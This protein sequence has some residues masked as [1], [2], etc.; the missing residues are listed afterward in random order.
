MSSSGKTA[1][2][3]SVNGGPIPLDHPMQTFLPYKDFERSAKVLDY[4]RLGKQRVETKQLL[5]ILLGETTKLGWRNHPAALMWQGHE[6][7]LARYGFEMSK[8]W[9]LRGYNDS[10]LDF[11]AERATDIKAPYWNSSRKF[12]RSHQSNL[13]RKDFNYYSRFFKNVPSN[14]EYEWPSKW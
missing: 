12:H 9:I 6:G 14:L 3:E 5:N 13:L 4:R 7:A 1:G 11:F 10:L 8:E 2:C